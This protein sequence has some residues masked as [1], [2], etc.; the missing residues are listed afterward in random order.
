M[1]LT[2]K[3]D[4][5][6]QVNALTLHAVEHMLNQMNCNII[7]N[8]L[9]SPIKKNYQSITSPYRQIEATF[10]IVYSH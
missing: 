9:D 2:Q 8:S 7:I 4:K 6:Q 10:F 3:R 1:Y 5:I